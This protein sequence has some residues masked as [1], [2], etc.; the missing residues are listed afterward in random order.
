[1]YVLNF[2]VWYY[3]NKA[4]GVYSYS[5]TMKMS[6]ENFQPYVFVLAKSV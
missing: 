2:D 1:V 3:I 5:Q 4:A 6:V